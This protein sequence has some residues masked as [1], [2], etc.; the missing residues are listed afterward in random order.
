MVK[1]EKIGQDGGGERQGGSGW[2]GFG[3]GKGKRRREVWVRGIFRPTMAGVHG[4][5]WGWRLLLVKI[6]LDGRP[7][8]VLEHDGS[9]RFPH[10]SRIWYMGWDEFQFKWWPELI[11][12]G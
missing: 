12:S 1:K 6:K 7:G 8:L 9:D 4:E 3:D 2:Y 5:E 11:K 10:R